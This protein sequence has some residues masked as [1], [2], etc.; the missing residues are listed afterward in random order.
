VAL[1]LSIISCLGSGIIR[2]QKQLKAMD[3][4]EAIEALMYVESNNNPNSINYKENAIGVLQIRKS[5]LEDL[6]R[7]YNKNYTLN[8]FYGEKGVALSKWAVIHY[9]RMYGADNNDLESMVRIWNGGP[10]GHTQMCTIN[11]WEK[12]KKVYLSRN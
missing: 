11:H 10:D 12:V 1:G 6:N 2:D 9:A 7:Y 8:D 3:L 5:A 4:N